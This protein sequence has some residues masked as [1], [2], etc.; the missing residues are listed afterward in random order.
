MSSN[1]N[2]P[3]YYHAI[4]VRYRILP[5]KRVKR[6]WCI[7]KSTQSDTQT[8]CDRLTFDDPRDG[9]CIEGFPS[10]GQHILGD[11]EGVVDAAVMCAVGEAA[12]G[13]SGEGNALNERYHAL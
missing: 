6:L 11:T 10:S 12:H 4:I 9:D 2:I 5:S 7:M 8:K 13:A 3:T 1:W